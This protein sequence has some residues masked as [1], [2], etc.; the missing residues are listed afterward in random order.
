MKPEVT[1]RTI[2]HDTT[3]L[4]LVEAEATI[5][6]MDKK[7]LYCTR[8]DPSVATSTPDAVVI[9]PFSKED[10]VTKIILVREFRIPLGQYQIGFPAGL[11]DPGETAESS[12]DRELLEETGYGVERI[13]EKSKPLATSAG[14][15]DETFQYVFCEA[16]YKQKQALESSED[17]EVLKLSL[18]ELKQIMDGPDPLCGRV[19]PICLQY[20]QT[21][22]F[23]R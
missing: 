20:T 19:W 11:I 17:I 15:T 5:R 10:G 13:F 18:P 6:G 12:A 2:A 14:L 7:W 4:K 21:N 8:K 22:Q 9:V 1:N 23:P 3:W 16:V